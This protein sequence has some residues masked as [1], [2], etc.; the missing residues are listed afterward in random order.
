[1][2]THDYLRQF[3]TPWK[4]EFKKRAKVLPADLQEGVKVYLGNESYEDKDLFSLLGK[5]SPDEFRALISTLAQVFFPQF[6]E[7]GANALE[8][9]LTRHSYPLGYERRAFRAPNHPLAV[10]RA[11]SWL[12]SVWNVI[13]DYPEQ[14]IEWFAIHAGLL[15]SWSSYH[16][17][18]LLAQAIDDGVDNVFQILKDTANTSHDIARM[19]RHVPTAL[20]ASQNEEAY[21]LAEGLLLAAQRQEG[22]RQAILESVD[23]ASPTAFTRMLDV[24]LREDLL[25]FA[26]T[27][28]AADVWFGFEYDVTDKKAVKA[29]LGQALDYLQDPDEARR[30]VQNGNAEQAYL[31]LYTLGMRNAVEAADLARTLLDSA[32]AA[33]RMA[34]VQ[35]LNAAEMFD[36]S[37]NARLL[38]DPDPRIG[39]LVAAKINRWSREVTVSFEDLAAY[40]ERLPKEAKQ[41]PLLFPWL[42]HIP[43]QTGVF[44]ELIATLDERPLSLL[45]PYVSRMSGYGKINLLERLKIRLEEEK[46]EPDEPTRAML[47]ELLQ[48][49]NSGVSQKA[50]GVM[51]LLSATPAEKEL[52]HKLLTRKSADL[53][54]G[55]IRWL[56]KDPA[57]AA[58]SAAALLATGNTEQRQAGLQLLEEIGAQPPEG[59]KPKNVTE[60]TLLAKL[61]TPDSGLSL[62]NGLGLYDP[63]DLAQPTPPKPRQRDFAADLRRGAELLKS[64][65]KFIVQHGET[66]ITGIGYD[67]SQ[68][69]LLMNLSGNW[70]RRVNSN[71]FPLKDLWEGWWNAREGAQ[72]GDATRLKW[73]IWHRV[74]RNDTTAAELAAELSEALDVDLD[75]ETVAAELPIALELLGIE[76][77]DPKTKDSERQKLIQQT[78][79][80]TFGPPIALKL[81]HPDLA[82]QVAGY[83]LDRFGT[84]TD[85]EM[86]LDAWETA[87]SYLPRDAKEMQHPHWEWH[88]EDPRDL[89]APLIPRQMHAEHFARLFNLHLWNNTAFPHL[90]K[91]LMGVSLLL[92]AE[93]LG[94]VSRPDLL[95][96]LIGP[97]PEREGY[98]YSGVRF[99]ALQDYTRRKLP[100][101]LPTSPAWMSAVNDVRDRVL[102]IEL[103]RG[104]LETPATNAALSLQSVFG[105]GLTLKLLAGM[106]KN[107]LKRGY[108]YNNTSKDA[109]FSHLLRVAFPAPD[110]SAATFKAAAKAMKLPD[111]RLL[112]LAMYAPQWA[113]LVSGAV[114]WKGLQDGVYWLH[115]HTKDSQWSVPAEVREAW[116]GEIAERTPLKAADLTEGA[117]DVA[118]FRQ[119]YKVLGKAHFETLLGAA[120]YASSS[121][122]HKRAELFAA[123]ILGEVTEAELLARIRDKRNQDAV[124][125][126]GLLPLAKGK[127]GAGQLEKRYLTLANFRKEAK[128]WGAQR[129]ASERLAADIGMQNLAR[130]AG[131]TDPQRLMWA[132]EARMAPDWQGAVTVDGV[133]VQAE[134]NDAGEASLT[135]LR[136]DK[137][138]KNLPP[139]LKKNPEI[140][141]LREAVKELDATR[142][143]MRLALEEAMVRGDHFSP[144]EIRDLAA[145][146]V[147]APM[148]KNLV[149]VLNEGALGLWNDGLLHTLGGEIVIQDEALRLAHPHDLFTSGQSA[150]KQ[151]REWQSH[152]LENHVSQPFKQVFR[153]Y[154]PL[155][156]AEQEAKRVTRY[157]GHH[158]QPNKAA[159]LLKA[160]GWVSVYEEGTRKTY[161]AEGINVWVDNLL[162]YGTPNEV[163]GMPLHAA[164]FVSRDTGE[165]LPLA[166]VPPRLFS[167]TMRDLDLVVSVAHVGGVDP[168]ASQSTVEM[169]E[170]LLRE[171]LRLLKVENVRL[172]NQHALIDGHYSRY[173]VHLGSGTVHRQPGGFV[174]IVPVHNQAAGRIFLPFADPDPRTAE[175]VSKVLLL[176]D[177]KKIGDPTILEQL[178]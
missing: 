123:A 48:D 2:D 100:E 26:A 148:L 88:R 156:A 115:A 174:C 127:K 75:D 87:L 167:E 111:T 13:Q 23:E 89:L 86:A 103:Q 147:I 171:T 63:A 104:D 21:A 71:D 72:E 79:H 131:Y 166:Q 77:P 91:N 62:D 68:T 43:A 143:R 163:E 124:R 35:F 22:L 138:L 107:P 84:P 3:Q 51:G 30:A 172:E 134:M 93:K 50:V 161:H 25:R 37:L 4:P 135:I 101:D 154:Y 112:D 125:S 90:Q 33:D 59:F 45:A 8:A 24:V 152:I 74:N 155:T 53:R 136:G 54:R 29:L 66:P 58:T 142:S 177:D 82:E 116:E 80:R 170:A 15:N 114:G 39:A 129:Q 47:L 83:F 55:L 5:K 10:R 102:D 137:P 176:A 132:M 57:G 73:A 145:H 105:A 118:W 96:K 173:S 28:R 31:A 27:L 16:L 36:E 44:N 157:E 98:S 40:A 17:G 32:N 6:P 109:T 76:N 159:A 133:T 130:T 165:V 1:M 140:V 18:L 113:D 7:T 46:T 119:M 169:R 49:R 92:E 158:V 168:E 12:H 65:D 153:E 126:L 175:V 42:G 38:A 162:G 120:K 9:I 99:D 85:S 41:E 121:G 94:L 122:G 160:R 151:W 150:G 110:D 52:A 81:K 146:P 97:R 64:L 106:G 164:Y 128:Q 139:A 14:S 70:L 19:G 56:A 60:E 78:L 117:V 95:R 141:A 178:R 11:A 67:P 34:A 69:Y 149:W 108:Q 20:L 61:V 144:Q